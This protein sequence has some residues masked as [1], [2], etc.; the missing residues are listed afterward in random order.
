M[1]YTTEQPGIK[2]YLTEAAELSRQETSG[3]WVLHHTSQGTKHDSIVDLPL[4]IVQG[5]DPS[6]FGR[7]WLQKVKINWAELARAHSIHA[8]TKTDQLTSLLQKYED[9]VNDKLGH[10]KNVKAQLHMLLRLY[11]TGKGTIPKLSVRH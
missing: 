9:V 4:V 7:N 5:Q 6:L 10:C 8:T 11:L 1:V 2:S 3:A